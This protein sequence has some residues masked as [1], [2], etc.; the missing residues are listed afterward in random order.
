MVKSQRSTLT[1]F[2][3]WS[4]SLPA[5]E[6]SST[7]HTPSTH[8]IGSEHGKRSPLPLAV[9]TTTGTPGSPS[10]L[11]PFGTSS[12][13][14]AIPTV[15]RPPS[16]VLSPSSSLY[17]PSL[18]HSATPKI[19]LASPSTSTIHYLFPS[20][21]SRHL[22]T[23]SA[24]R[25]V[26]ESKHLGRT[27]SVRRHQ[28]HSRTHSTGGSLG[29]P[30]YIHRSSYEQSEKELHIGRKILENS[31][32][33]PPSRSSDSIVKKRDIVPLGPAKRV[34]SGSNVKKSDISAPVPVQASKRGSAVEGRDP[35]TSGIKEANMRRLR[36]QPSMADLG[37]GRGLQVEVMRQ[38]FVSNFTLKRDHILGEIGNQPVRVIVGVLAGSVIRETNGRIEKTFLLGQSSLHCKFNKN[39]AVDQ[40]IQVPSVSVVAPIL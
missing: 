14:P 3:Q 31:F 39:K 32:P 4:T 29:R 11:D 27:G 15:F 25:P 20:E 18:T 21:T 17:T 8:G 10:Q 13:L 7:P 2:H 38:P 28:T 37:K 24:T 5:T 19:V 1:L 34:V 6:R 22:S 33:L 12:T 9:A 35:Q 40:V 26:V 23:A 16:G 36:R 30:K